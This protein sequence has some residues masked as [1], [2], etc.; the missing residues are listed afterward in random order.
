MYR[1]S[2]LAVLLLAMYSDVT[3]CTSAEWPRESLLKLK[4]DYNQFMNDV[5]SEIQ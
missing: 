3:A 4:K 2:V 1:F 5:L